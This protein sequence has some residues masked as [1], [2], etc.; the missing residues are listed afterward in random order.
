[1]EAQNGSATPPAQGEGRSQS[2]GLCHIGCLSPASSAGGRD[3]HVL[4]RSLLTLHTPVPHPQQLLCLKETPLPPPGLL[5]YRRGSP[6]LALPQLV[7]ESIPLSPDHALFRSTGP[8]DPRPVSSGVGSLG[9]YCAGGQ[10]E[11][12]PAERATGP[13]A[14][15][16]AQLMEQ[17]NKPSH[18]DIFI[19]SPKQVCLTPRQEGKEQTKDTIWPVA[20]LLLPLS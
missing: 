2:V 1:M 13:G 9:V 15:S 17:S 8:Q 18:A 20:R 14:P 3:C 16:L 6:L 4:A 12:P 7:P 10:G 11:A 5:K 19:F